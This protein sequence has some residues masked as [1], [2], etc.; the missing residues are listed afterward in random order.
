MRARLITLGSNELY[1]IKVIRIITNRYGVTIP[2]TLRKLSGNSQGGEINIFLRQFSGNS[3][4]L[5]RC[6]VAHTLPYR[7]SYS[8][9]TWYNR[10][11]RTSVREGESS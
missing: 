9:V 5:R 10:T 4:V 6:D 11:Y 8:A 1:I 2:Q 3:Q 7:A